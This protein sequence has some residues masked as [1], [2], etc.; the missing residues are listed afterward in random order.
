MNEIGKA[1]NATILVADDEPSIRMLMEAALSAEGYRVFTARNGYEALRV[2]DERNADIDLVI[3]DMCMPYIAGSE[4]IAALQ[5]R[6]STLKCLCISGY[7][8]NT[9]LGLP[10][11]QEPFSRKELLRSVHDALS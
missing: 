3:A 4:L 9:G 11:L 6:C 7:A 5:A 1:T 10:L 2:F 8:V